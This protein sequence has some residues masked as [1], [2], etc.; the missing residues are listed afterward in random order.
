MFN[1]DKKI[2]ILYPSILCSY[3]NENKQKK[4]TNN[5]QHYAA[6]LNKK[7]KTLSTES[8]CISKILHEN[9]KT[10]LKPQENPFLIVCLEPPLLCLFLDFI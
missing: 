1:K 3:N 4:K 2:L 5:K 9:N 8:H 10:S 6:K 7:Q